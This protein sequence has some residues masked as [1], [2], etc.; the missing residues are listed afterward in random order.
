MS[1]CRRIADKRIFV[2]GSGED[3]RLQRRSVRG[4]ELHA[5]IESDRFVVLHTGRDGLTRILQAAPRAAAPSAATKAESRAD[6][7]AMAE[8]AEAAAAKHEAKTPAPAPPH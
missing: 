2:I 1:C 3:Q 7:E 8:D 5:A 6:A 4:A